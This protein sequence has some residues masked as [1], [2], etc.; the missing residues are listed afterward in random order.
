MKKTLIIIIILVMIRSIFSFTIDKIS[1]F[2]LTDSYDLNKPNMAL[3]DNFLYSINHRSLQIFDTTNN[4]LNLVTDFNLEGPVVTLCVSENYAYI[5][6]GSITSR[7][8]R[9]DITDILNPT[10]IDTITY[11]GN[12]V[13]FVD[14]NKLFVNELHND[15]SWTVHVYDEETFVEI[16]EFEVPQSTHAMEYVKNGIASVKTLTDL[17][18]YDIMDP[19]NLLLINSNPIDSYANYKP[20]IV[21]DSV[22]FIDC[23]SGMKIFDI[24]I[25]EEWIT[26]Y[27]FTDP[28]VIDYEVLDN[29]LILITFNALILYDV[30]DLSQPIELDIQYL[31]PYEDNCWSVIGTGNSFFVK[32]EQGKLIS[33]DISAN[34]IQYSDVYNNVGR[35]FSMHYYN[36]NVYIASSLGAIQQFNLSNLNL[37]ELVD[38]Y[39]SNYS[40]F[41][42]NGAEDI[43]V[44]SFLDPIQ[45]LYFN[46]ILKIENSGELTELCTFNN[47][48]QNQMNIYLCEGIGYFYVNNSILYKYIIN[49]FNEL[50]EVATL[51]LPDT[52]VVGYIYFNEGIAYIQCLDK[53]AIVDQIDSDNMILANEL[54]TQSCYDEIHFY[55]N[56]LIITSQL[57][58]EHCSI[59]YLNN[60]LSP[61]FIL[62]I[63]HSGLIA[64]D[65]QN[66]LMFLGSI[67]C[68]VFDLSNIQYGIVDQV[69]S[70]RNWSNCVEI[71]PF[72]RDNENYLIYLEDSSCS[73]YQYDYEPNQISDEIINIKS[74][75]SNCPNPF[76]PLTKITYTLFEPGKITLDIYN[77]KGQKVKSLIDSEQLSGTY[78]VYWNGGDQYNKPVASGVYF[79]TLKTETGNVSRKMILLK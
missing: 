12:Y 73:I 11:W 75:L 15:W 62:N 36:D 5:S 61:N 49:E 35:I 40:A 67:V 20:T 72:Q 32:T 63:N 1:E 56:Y 51:Q 34:N 13:H 45:P 74:Q 29:I 70:F 68:E 4:E 78:E 25:P 22:L 7:L 50:I 38:T 76:N 64:I 16:T 17:Y 10:I 59:Y 8:Y 57:P 41:G 66:E 54:N 42:S 71:I 14:N 44:T 33:F 31:N 53:L 19:F 55:Q 28:N 30:S 37:P 27:T 9:I 6:T 46:K 52:Y 2:S 60:P 65:E 23:I 18:F 26:I 24:T 79:C 48:T 69:G 77:A 43:F 39:Y 58:E 21:Q 3:K 47:L